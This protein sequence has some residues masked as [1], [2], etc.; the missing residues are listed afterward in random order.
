MPERRA[1]I[2]YH[3]E[4]V[5]P[6]RVFLRPGEPEP[7]NCPDGHGAMTRQ[8]NVPYKRPDTSKPVGRSKM[9]GPPPTRRK[10]QRP[11]ARS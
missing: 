11:K 8:V 9:V 1:F 10:P 4:C 2:C 3:K 5:P 7:P 6:H